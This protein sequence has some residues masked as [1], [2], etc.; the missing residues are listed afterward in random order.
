MVVEIKKTDLEKKYYNMTN[1]D[2]AAE[3][4]IG[5]VTL[6][7]LLQDSG[8]KMKGKGRHRKKKIKII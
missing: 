1:D 8:I 3:L 7:K 5:Q 4:G 6:V 2:L